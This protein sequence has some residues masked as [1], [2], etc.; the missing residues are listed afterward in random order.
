MP[1]TD[2]EAS[3]VELVR[4]HSGGCGVLTFRDDSGMVVVGLR[5]SDSGVLGVDAVTTM[6]TG[7]E[8]VDV[9]ALGR[10]IL[11]ALRTDQDGAN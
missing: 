2:K 3:L 11:K 5:L 10:A 9:A 4:K 6:R 7:A 1:M 8:G